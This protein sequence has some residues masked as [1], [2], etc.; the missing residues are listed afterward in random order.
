MQSPKSFFSPPTLTLPS[1]PRTHRPRVISHRA[2]VPKKARTSQT[3]N[4]VAAWR[5]SDRALDKRPRVSR[6]ERERRRSSHYSR[7]PGAR[8]AG[9]S[10]PPRT[11]RNRTPLQRACV[12]R[13]TVLQTRQVYTLVLG[14]GI[15]V[16]RAP[17]PVR[18]R[19][20]WKRAVFC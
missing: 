8:N 3:E 1:S 9:V 6:Y 11:W 7:S 12:C 20:Q 17:A 15:V 14:T 10:N 2:S 4:R 13:A 19:R 16:G 18:S 5:D